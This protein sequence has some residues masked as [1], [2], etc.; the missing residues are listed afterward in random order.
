LSSGT[1]VTP[2]FLATDPAAAPAADAAAPAASPAP[3]P[4]PAETLPIPSR[5][6]T[7]TAANDSALPT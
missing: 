5:P 7:I 2:M 3:F 4:A 1:I 6:A